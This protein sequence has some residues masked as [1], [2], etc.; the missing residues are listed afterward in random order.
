[1]V[2]IPKTGG[3]DGFS[4]SQCYFVNNSVVIAA[5]NVLNDPDS[6]KSEQQPIFD[7]EERE[8]PEVH[9]SRA[10]DIEVLIAISA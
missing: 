4:Q 7:L 5:K 9:G 8:I 2:S 10:R 6:Q 3:L 1:M